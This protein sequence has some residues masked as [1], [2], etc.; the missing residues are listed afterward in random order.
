VKVVNG[1]RS[2]GCTLS[3]T[4][5]VA[6]WLTYWM[7]DAVIANTFAG[8]TLHLPPP[9]R[10]HAVWNGIDLD[11]V[12]QRTFVEPGMRQALFGTPDARVMCFVGSMR[13]MKDVLLAVRTARALAD[14]D[15]RWRFMF[16]GDSATSGSHK[17]ANVLA[18][19]GYKTEVRDEVAKLQ[20]EGSTRFLGERTDAMSLIASSDLLVC[21]SKQEGFPKVIL[22]A[23]AVGTPA[24]STEVSDIRRI[25]P[26][27]WQ[28]VGKRTPQTM[29]D[30]IERSMHQREDVVQRQIEF[31]ERNA[32]LDHACAKLE[33]V[34][35]RYSVHAPRGRS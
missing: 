15:A 24:V 19:E 8:R 25:L 2:N 12:R 35:A 20:L 1:E 22:E 27:E 7:A 16:I 17:T 5:S 23:M 13:P 6:H 9:Q 28:V 33:E 14:R 31:V 30:A 18:E 32:T 4:Q 29:A 11:E 10:P 3:R 21:T 34:L 26:F